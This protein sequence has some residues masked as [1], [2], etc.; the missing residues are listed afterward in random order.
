[1]V[2]ALND[3][4]ADTRAYAT[5]ALG[6]LL[7]DPNVQ[8]RREAAA[9]LRR[10]GPNAKAAISMLVEG[11]KDSDLEVRRECLEAVGHC[12]AD[13]QAA[14]A[15][16]RQLLADPDTKLRQRTV[17]LLALLGPE[18]RVAVPELIVA[19]KDPRLQDD[20]VAT[21]A[22]VGKPAVPSLLGA[23]KEHK[24]LARIGIC[25]ALGEIGPEAREA[26]PALSSLLRDEDPAVRVAASDALRRILGRN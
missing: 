3:K 23:L 2:A 9:I 14:L 18:A 12:G 25:R 5:R 22:K 21:L 6:G 8:T 4:D 26:R 13:A 17:Q 7:K 15:V 16:L 20:V 1:V 10:A 24:G 19:L 11:L